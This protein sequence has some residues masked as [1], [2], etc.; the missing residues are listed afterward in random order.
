MSKAYSL[1]LDTADLLKLDKSRVEKGKQ[2]ASL[3]LQGVEI[4]VSC[5]EG[6][7]SV[8]HAKFAY[9]GMDCSII[10][11]EPFLSDYAK[12]LARMIKSVAYK[13]M[14]SAPWVGVVVKERLAKK[15]EK[16]NVTL[17]NDHVAILTLPATSESDEQLQLSIV[18]LSGNEIGSHYYRVNYLDGITIG[19]VIDVADLD[20]AINDIVNIAERAYD[21]W[22]EESKVAPQPKTDHERDM[23]DL[24][25]FLKTRYKNMKDSSLTFTRDS[26]GKELSIFN[27]KNGDNCCISCDST[28]GDIKVHSNRGYSYRDKRFKRDDPKRFEK[29]ASVVFGFVSKSEE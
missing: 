6:E 14:Y 12:K 1:L 10:E 3:R 28:T 24:Y 29:V 15:I 16:C 4:T 13:K 19:R 23:A 5:T 21:K 7:N 20:T 9:S 2:E 26:D 27:I 22:V 8:A 11:S 17:E 25:Q 18:E